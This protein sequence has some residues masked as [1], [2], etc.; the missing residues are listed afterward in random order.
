MKILEL[1]L[2]AFGPFTDVRLDFA[3][4]GPGMHII[5][6]PNEAG[7]SSALRALTALLF[8]I[9][10]NTADNFVHEYQQLR[11]GG[12]LRSAAGCELSFLRRKG[13]SNTLLTPQGVPLDGVIWKSTC[14]AW[15]NSFS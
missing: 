6:G 13:R 8:G 10:H 12:K 15:I 9:D 14:T 5:F 1:Q 4:V 11:I 7:K 3:G 2:L